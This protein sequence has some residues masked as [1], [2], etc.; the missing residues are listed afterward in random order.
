MRDECQLEDIYIYIYIFFSPYAA[1]GP[2]RELHVHPV[3]YASVSIIWQ[4]P[5]NENGN[6]RYYNISA[7]RAQPGTNL[8]D[9]VVQ[10]ADHNE[11]SYLMT[12]LKAA[13]DY[14]ISISAV[15]ILTGPVVTQEVTTKEWGK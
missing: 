6:I 8:S 9:V 12:N 15:T 5:Q 13:T 3:S 7:A 11:I 14:V 2:V 10:R 1:P 4:R